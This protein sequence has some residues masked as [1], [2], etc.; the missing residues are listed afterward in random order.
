MLVSI[1]S[2]SALH[3]E[4]V[5]QEFNQATQS[6]RLVLLLWFDGPNP[7]TYF[8]PQPHLLTQYM[9]SAPVYLLDCPQE[10]D[11]RLEEVATLLSH[12]PSIV[13][14][15]RAAQFGL[16]VLFA[17]GCIAVSMC[18]YLLLWIAGLFEEIDA[19][20][21][22]GTS[23]WITLLP[24]IVLFPHIYRVPTKYRAT[25]VIH[26]FTFMQYFLVAY[27]VL[28]A[29]WHANPA[30]AFITLPFVSLFGLVL[31]FVV[32]PVVGS[33]RRFII[34]CGLQ[35][36]AS[37]K[38]P[39]RTAISTVIVLLT[40]GLAYGGTLMARWTAPLLSN[41]SGEVSSFSELS[42]KIDI[43]SY[44][45]TFP[46]KGRLK[47]TRDWDLASDGIHWK[48]T[49][50]GN[51]APDDAVTWLPKDPFAKSIY[52]L[53]NPGLDGIAPDDGRLRRITEAI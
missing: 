40:L 42:K 52:N 20:Y 53:H 24:L 45:D 27:W 1:A 34:R 17:A 33:L 44:F 38:L 49:V 30:M 10:S 41:N 22:F 9:P 26:G 43:G 18:L 4:W 19:L 16:L 3:S 35:R 51:C 11:I 46:S 39:P 31:A 6:C 29:M 36:S 23:L 14:W 21:V 15:G 2:K 37:P 5:R 12:L 13:A 32:I 48:C 25:K 7:T 50:E 47:W 8:V 28:V